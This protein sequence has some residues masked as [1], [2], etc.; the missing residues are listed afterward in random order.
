MRV[1]WRG[2]RRLI[3][4]RSKSPARNATE[5]AVG[6]AAIFVVFYGTRGGTPWRLVVG[7]L[8]LAAVGFVLGFGATVYGGRRRR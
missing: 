1:A 6:L 8:A 7:T 2:F 3:S 5:M 4:G